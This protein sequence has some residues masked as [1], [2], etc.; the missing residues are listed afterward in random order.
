MGLFTYRPSAM[1]QCE[2]DV[3]EAIWTP[4][5]EIFTIWPFIGKVG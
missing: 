5:S 3:M 2:V 1:Q 4:K